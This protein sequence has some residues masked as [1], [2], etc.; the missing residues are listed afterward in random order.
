MARKTRRLRKHREE[1]EDEPEWEWADDIQDPEKPKRNQIV[2]HTSAKYGDVIYKI[3]DIVQ[4]NSEYAY[5]WVG[6]ITG[7]ETNYAFEEKERMRVLTLWFYRQQDVKN[8]KRIK[9]ADLVLARN[10]TADSRA[11]FTSAITEMMFSFIRL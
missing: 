7:F 9:G 4:I 1:E 10:S 2:K 8:E 3:G 6:M 11:R 5:K